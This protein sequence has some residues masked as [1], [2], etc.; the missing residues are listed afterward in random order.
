M[1][2]TKSVEDGDSR[3]ID[4]I[5]TEV[6][7]NEILVDGVG[8]VAENDHNVGN[9]NLILILNRQNCVQLVQVILSPSQTI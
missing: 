1:F 5:F 6:V 4:K 2:D 7:E 9:D 8:N 3:N